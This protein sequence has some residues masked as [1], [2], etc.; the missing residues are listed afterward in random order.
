M[1]HL[2][3]SESA[4]A[5]LSMLTLLPLLFSLVFAPSNMRKIAGFWFTGTLL[6]TGVAVAVFC[7]TLV[8]NPFE[9]WCLFVERYMVVTS[10]G[11]LTA[12][13]VMARRIHTSAAEDSTPG[14]GLFFL[15]AAVVLATTTY[16]TLGQAFSQRDPVGIAVPKPT[17]LY[18]DACFPFTQDISLGV[19]FTDAPHIV[20]SICIIIYAV[21]A[22]RVGLSMVL[23]MVIAL[24]NVTYF[25]PLIVVRATT[26]VSVQYEMEHRWLILAEAALWAIFWT[27][28]SATTGQVQRTFAEVHEMEKL[29]MPRVNLSVHRPKFNVNLHMPVISLPRLNKL[30]S[31]EKCDDLTLTQTGVDGKIGLHS[32]DTILRAA[33]KTWTS[34]YEA[35]SIKDVGGLLP[36]TK[37][38]EQAPMLPPLPAIYRNQDGRFTHKNSAP[39]P[40][41][42]ASPP[43]KCKD[44]SPRVQA[45]AMVVYPFMAGNEDIIERLPGDEKPL[46]AM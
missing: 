44:T 26:D 25:L 8:V 46:M 31:P 18:S 12:L 41:S 36:P 40:V 16:A 27:W 19:V 33:R 5:V 29:Q 9:G 22:L 4:L 10:I 45:P 14:K 1:I 6:T 42:L 17:G 11:T 7:D 32:H 15:D 24:L 35:M 13:L 2:P 20:L 28:R 39:G 21:L 43:K 34:Q 38:G 30:N 37:E 3:P 23:L